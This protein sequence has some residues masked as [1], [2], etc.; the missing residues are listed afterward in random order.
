VVTVVMP[1]RNEA[2]SIRESLGAVLSQDYPAGRL[3]VIVVD[4]MSRDGTPSIVRRIMTRHG[5]V[6]LIENPRGI[7]PS[8]LN[9]AI[10][11]ATGQVIVRVDGHTLVEPDYVS[12]CVAALRRSGAENVGGPMR[13]EGSGWF[14]SAV[15]L[16]TSSRFGVGGA[17]FHYSG[18]EERVDTVYLGAWRRSTFD[19][20]GLFD[21]E[22]V[23][24]QDDEF[25]YRLRSRG[26]SVLLSP[27]IRSRYT[28]RG[29]PASLWRQYFQYGFWKVR[30][31]QKHPRQI[32][33]RHLAPPALV[34]ALF[35]PLAASAIEPRFAILGVAVAGA[36][37]VATFVASVR[38]AG[39]SGWR[40][41]PALGLAFAILHMGYGL[42]F[43]A[44]L[45][46]YAFRWR[47]R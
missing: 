8:G 45:G 1:V 12:E 36:Y 11:A 30:V 27:K 35:A 13:A 41:L 25:N 39:L 21:E 34:A 38:I 43:L 17:R 20:F 14:G 31:M 10:R 33:P 46:R 7:V 4:G 19:R 16:A 5:N 3:E 37:A 22:M 28:V 18:L 40:R 15:A 29:T 32:R 2:A 26:G 42:G 44:G 9:D 24:N 47:D 6:R 23:R